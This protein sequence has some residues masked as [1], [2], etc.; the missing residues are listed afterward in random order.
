[1]SQLFLTTKTFLIGGM[2]LG[3]SYVIATTWGSFFTAYSQEIM[4]RLRCDKYKDDDDRYNACLKEES[5]STRF[6]TA[7]ATTFVLALVALLIVW[8]SGLKNVPSKPSVFGAGS[9]PIP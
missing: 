4:D 1:M 7:L 2:F 9:A 6:F 3:I 5:V 8:L